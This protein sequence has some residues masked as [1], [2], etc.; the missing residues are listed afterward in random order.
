[1]VVT[2]LLQSSRTRNLTVL[3][4]P[5]PR[6]TNVTF[7]AGS[8]PYQSGEIVGVNV[9]WSNPTGSGP[10]WVRLMEGGSQIA[11]KSYASVGPG[12]N[13]IAA[14]SFTMPSRDVSFVVEAGTIA[15][16]TDVIGPLQVQLLVQVAT[17]LT[18]SISPSTV[19]PGETVSYGGTLTRNDT[20]GDV[21]SQ[22][23]SIA[24]PGGTATKT[25]DGGGNYSGSFVA[26]S[27]GSYNIVASFGGTASLAAS[28]SSRALQIGAISPIMVLIIA[29][30]AYYLLR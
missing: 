18:L 19:S 26:P 7:P 6:I 24:I 11:S 9:S 15:T 22:T 3:A 4:L 1:M 13:G 8:G 16:V 27:A 10:M 12:D 29:A 14:L 5:A 30:G 23:I 2:Q 20:G 21:P 17:S 28:S 25:T